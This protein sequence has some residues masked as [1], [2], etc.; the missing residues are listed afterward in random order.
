MSDLFS[1]FGGLS[2]NSLIFLTQI[3]FRV[4][5]FDVVV[6]VSPFLALMFLSLKVHFSRKYFI[7]FYDC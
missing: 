1:T 7:T 3:L 6:V 5:V 4:E 2:F